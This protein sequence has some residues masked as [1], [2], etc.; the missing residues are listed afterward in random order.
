MRDDLQIL[1]P[2]KN[3]SKNCKVNSINCDR[4]QTEN[5]NNMKCN[6]I[7]PKKPY[8]KRGTGLA[9]YGLSLDEIK[10]KNGKLK[11]HKPLK[12]IPSK[13]K[14]PRNCLNQVIQFPRPEFGKSINIFF[15]TIT[16]YQ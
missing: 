9:R 4:N 15:K 11:F 16:L 3:F 7:N 5:E 1:S 12:S 6:N 14:V 10:K 8:L 2:N 13:I